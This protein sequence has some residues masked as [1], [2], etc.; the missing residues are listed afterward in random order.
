MLFYQNE[1]ILIII[2]II[3]AFVIFGFIYFSTNQ[4]KEISKTNING[5]PVKFKNK[6]IYIPFNFT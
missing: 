5:I 2:G 3:I 4:A 6:T 1:I